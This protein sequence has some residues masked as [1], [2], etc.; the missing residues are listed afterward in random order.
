M[1]EMKCRVRYSET[2]S[3]G[4]LKLASL[5]DLFQDC[6]IF[7]AEDAGIGCDYMQENGWA[8]MLVSWEISIHKL[9]RMGERL[10]ITTDPYD[11]KSFLGFRYFKMYGENGDETLVE[12]NTSW[13]F[14]DLKRQA[15]TRFP[16]EMPA[17]YGMGES[18]I[19]YPPAKRKMSIPDAD[20]AQAGWQDLP[21]FDVVPGNIDINNH[22]NNGQY[23]HMANA[24]LPD[25]FVIGGIR[26]E[27]KKQAKLGDRIYPRISDRN[28]DETGRRERLINLCDE[29]RNTYCA[30]MFTEK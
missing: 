18:G 4:Q 9:P 26:V 30:V 21:S 15:P 6:S 3:T 8:W 10:V 13:A 24:Y 22:V 2:D 14:M 1:Y 29:E 5:V 23:I 25:D 28:V 7:H 27:Y 20:D 19:V 16:K 12:A 17:L 11:F